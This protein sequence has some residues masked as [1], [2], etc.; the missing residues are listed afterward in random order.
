[1]KIDTGEHPPIKLTYRTPLNNRKDI[2]NAIDEMF[3]AKTIQRSKSPWSFS[4]VIVDKKMAPN[5]LCEF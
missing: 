3:G 1:M 2:D 4:V 5:V